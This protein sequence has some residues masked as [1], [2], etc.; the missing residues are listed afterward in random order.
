MTENKR[1]FWRFGGSLDSI[2][3]WLVGLVFLLSLFIHASRSR[4]PEAIGAAIGQTAFIAVVLFMLF[5]A[6]SV[7]KKRKR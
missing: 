6:I 4:L 2:Y 1:S 7:V 5:K 3:N